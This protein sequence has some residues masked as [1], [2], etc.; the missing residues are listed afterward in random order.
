MEGSSGGLLERLA[1]GPVVGDGS[2][3]VTLERRGYVDIGFCTPEATV[4]YPEAVTQLH[5]EFLRA[6][7][8]VM[9]TFSYNSSDNCLSFKN[10]NEDNE[11]INIFQCDNLSRRAC[12]LAREVAKEGNAL[13]AGSVSPVVEYMTLKEKKGAI[14]EF[15][16][17]IE[18]FIEKKVDFLI[19]EFFGHIFEAEWA[20]EAMKKSG[21]PVACTMK[22]GP[23]GDLSGISPKE[24]AVR[25]AKAGADLVGI[26]CNYDPFICLE[27]IKMMKDALEEEGLSCYLM[28][29]PVGWHTQEIRNDVRGYNALPEWPLAMESRLVTRTD[30]RKFARA[31]YD[32]GVSYIGGCCGFEP[33]HI[34]A[35]AEELAEERGRRPPG[36]DK[37]C[38]YHSLRNSVRQN[39]RNRS[40]RKYWENLNPATGR[41]NARVLA[42]LDET[43]WIL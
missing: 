19:G 6:G 17:Q 8:D 32:L 12:D 34:R 43:P 29:Q 9:Q 16:K 18:I 4:Q 1:K 24:C 3:V 37:S 38:N 22:I 30:V 10:I 27:T 13:V 21:M 31:A 15:K 2:F 42:K 5:R 20:I 28:A 41:K 26:N 36:K 23:A 39:Q 33:Y 40:D 11:T 14:E 7:A 35:I 25:M